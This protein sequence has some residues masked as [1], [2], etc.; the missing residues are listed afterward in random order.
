MFFKLTLYANKSYAPQSG[1]DN[2]S[3]NAGINNL[4]GG[5]F[6][7]YINTEEIKRLG[8]NDQSYQYFVEF[9][10]PPI[11]F[12]SQ[13]FFVYNA[14]TNEYNSLKEMA[15]YIEGTEKF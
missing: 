3:S 14:G 12:V 1:Y 2:S 10:S 5:Q 4:S 13:T 11:P 15:N 9:K 7:V 6:I 8:F